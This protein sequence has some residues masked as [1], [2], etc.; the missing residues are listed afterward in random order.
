MFIIF[1]TN[2][3]NDVCFIFEYILWIF[4]KGDQ[5][6]YLGFKDMWGEHKSK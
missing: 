6:G 3:L 5:L 1:K 4:L 2:K